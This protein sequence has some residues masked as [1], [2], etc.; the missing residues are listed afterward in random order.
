MAKAIRHFYGT[1][2]YG[3]HVEK[4][5]RVDGSWFSRAY[6]FNGYAKAWSKWLECDK[7]NF[8]THVTNAY[9]GVKEKLDSPRCMWGFNSLNELDGPHKIRL[10]N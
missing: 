4:A 8:E 7:P 6:E 1:E 9:T 5:Q 2:T 10:P 3:R